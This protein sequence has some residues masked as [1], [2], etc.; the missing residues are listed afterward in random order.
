MNQGPP[1]CC[2]S[3]EDGFGIVGP[4]GELG[5]PED[6]ATMFNAIHRPSTAESKE[7]PALN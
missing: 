2:A 4:C 5:R 7:K 3:G 6:L 1:P